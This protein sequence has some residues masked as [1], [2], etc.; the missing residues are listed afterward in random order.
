MSSTKQAKKVSQGEG[1]TRKVLARA[2]PDHQ[3]AYNS[4]PDWLSGLE[5]DCYSKELNLAVE[6]N[7]RQHEVYTP[8]FHRDENGF[9]HQIERDL[10][11]AGIAEE[12]G[13][14]LIVIPSKVPLTKLRAHILGQLIKLG[15]E[16]EEGIGSPTE[17]IVAPKPKYQCQKCGK[18]STD[19]SNYRKHLARKTP[20]TLVLEDDDLTDEQKDNPNKCKHCGRVFTRHTSMVAHMKKACKAARSDKEDDGERPPKTSQN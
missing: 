13:T 12:R 9:Y 1:L 4:R 7:G 19:A 11:K 6:Y 17:A 2:F 8:F 10:R 18:E 15:Y 16:P 20:C 3:F 14:I 5:F